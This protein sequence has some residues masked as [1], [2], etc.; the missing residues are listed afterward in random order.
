MRLL[1][2]SARREE[3]QV[4]KCS[5][6][7][8]RPIVRYLPAYG[9]MRLRHVRCG[10]WWFVG[11]TL[12]EGCGANTWSGVESWFFGLWGPLEFLGGPGFD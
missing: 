4:E 12:R 1:S 5:P 10:T 6:W 3:R 9:Q 8:K 2:A 7:R 11:E